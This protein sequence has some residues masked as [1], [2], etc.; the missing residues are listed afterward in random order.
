M[1]RRIALLVLLASAARLG[2]GSSAL[3]G[4]FS[5]VGVGTRP[6]GMG[7]AFV[8]LADD[9]NAVQENPAGMAFFDK[10]ARFAGFTHSSLFGLSE[11]S[12]D[13][14]SYAQADSGYSAFGLAW[15]RFAANIDPD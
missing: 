2:A 10:A 14:L 4:V 1:T 3:G 11:L 13:Y 9:A 7:G 15:S 8:A 6:L 5:A 12:R